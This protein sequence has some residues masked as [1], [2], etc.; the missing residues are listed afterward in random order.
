MSW[1]ATRA[2]ALACEQCSALGCSPW[3]CWASV[4]QAASCGLIGGRGVGVLGLLKCITRCAIVFQEGTELTEARTGRVVNSSELNA[5]PSKAQTRG[6][7]CCQL[8]LREGVA[9]GS[10][11]ASAVAASARGTLGDGV[12]VCRTRRVVYFGLIGRFLCVSWESGRTRLRVCLDDGAPAGMTWL[13]PKAVLAR[14]LAPDIEALRKVPAFQRS[15]LSVQHA[16]LVSRS[17]CRQQC[18]HRAFCLPQLDQTA[19]VFAARVCARDAAA[20]QRC[21]FN[22]QRHT[23][24]RRMAEPRAAAATPSTVAKRDNTHRRPRPSRRDPRLTAARGC[25]TSAARSVNQNSS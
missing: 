11:L 22:W 6:R 2:D 16:A 15:Y 5:R 13:S 9:K 4:L 8:W 10:G 25:R 7:G 1:G 14:C 20:G 18:P 12:A 3:A 19:A 17:V 24:D 23:R 21:V